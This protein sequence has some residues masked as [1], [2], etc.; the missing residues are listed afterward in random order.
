MYEKLQEYHYALKT[1]GYTVASIPQWG[2]PGCTLRLKDASK[3]DSEAF[4]NNLLHWQ[5]NKK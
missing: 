4:R 1:T 2:A 5:I 3:V